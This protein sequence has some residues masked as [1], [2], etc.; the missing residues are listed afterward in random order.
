MDPNPDHERSSNPTE[1]F[2]DFWLFHSNPEI[3]ESLVKDIDFNKQGKW[4]LFY[5][6]GNLDEAWSK[7]KDLYDK[8]ELTGIS[9]M[10]VSTAAK[11]PRATSNSSGVIICY[12]GPFDNETAQMQYG[13]NLID[14]MDY[15]YGTQRCNNG[16][17]PYIYYK[18]DEM[19]MTGTAATGQRKNYLYKLKILIKDE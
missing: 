5:D 3:E 13:Q 8:R 4:M 17:P 10:K 2:D 16:R 19:T 6:N 9:S 18:P 7:I 1:T 11:N 15:K 12:C 14:K